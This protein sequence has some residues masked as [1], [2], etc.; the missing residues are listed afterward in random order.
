ML[1]AFANAFR[2]PDL[3]K[4]I[5]FT[6]GDPGHLPA[7]LDHP[8]AQRQRRRRSTSACSQATSGRPAGALLPDQPVLRRGAAPAGDLRAGDHALHH[9]QHHPAAAD[10]GDPAAGGPQEGGPV[11]ADED[12][13]VHA[14]PDPGPRGAELDR[15]RDRRGQRPAVHRLH[16]H[17][18]RQGHLPGHRDDPDDDRRH[19]RHHVARRAHHRARRRQRHVGD[20]LHPDRRHLPQRAVEPQGRPPGLA[21][22]G[23]LPARDRASAWS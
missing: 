23:R 9:R 15:V 2:T 18:L 6:L 8:D 10:R 14:L 17:R 20:D 19:Q 11:R 1:S 7:G 22:L 21:G 3:R 13:P 16:R 5:F 12:H 4:K